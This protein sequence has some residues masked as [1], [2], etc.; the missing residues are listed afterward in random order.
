MLE[1][2]AHARAKMLDEVREL[3]QKDVLLLTSIVES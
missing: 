3:A 2:V 1:K